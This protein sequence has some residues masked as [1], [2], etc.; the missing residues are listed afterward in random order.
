ML[1]IFGIGWTRLINDTIPGVL[2]RVTLPWIHGAF[3]RVCFAV[4][5][6]DCIIGGASVIP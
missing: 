4:G 1:A 6:R 3:L 2:F 5:L